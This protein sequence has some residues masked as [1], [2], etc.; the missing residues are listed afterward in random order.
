[1]PARFKR[2]NFIDPDF[3]YLKILQLF[4]VTASDSRKA[5]LHKALSFIIV[6]NKYCGK[7]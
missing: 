5:V 3:F 2:K 6:T 1:M 4:F 7:F